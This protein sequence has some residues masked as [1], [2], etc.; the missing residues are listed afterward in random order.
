[1]QPQA[2]GS[3][4]RN[5][6]WVT[7]SSVRVAP[8]RT[9]TRFSRHLATRAPRRA[10]PQ[11][12]FHP[13]SGGSKRA[14]M[15][16]GCGSGVLVYGNHFACYASEF[17]NPTANTW[18]RTNGTCGTAVSYGPLTLLGTGKAL[19]ASRWFRN[20]QR[21]VL[22]ERQQLPLRP[23]HQLVDRHGQAEPSWKS[24][25][26][27]ALERASTGRRRCRR[28]TVYALTDA[29][30]IAILCSGRKAASAGG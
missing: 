3:K 13:T 7:P 24:H 9:G 15:T 19:L 1:V 12:C 20:I 22:P 18:S 10:G 8:G 29:A 21:Q 2:P 25:A 16:L 28:G 5:V 14:E 6:S 27:K 23:V 4:S 26:N 17:H 11:N 30:A